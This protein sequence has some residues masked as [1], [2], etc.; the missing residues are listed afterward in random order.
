V[1]LVCAAAIV[2][3]VDSNVLDRGGYHLDKIVRLRQVRELSVT[4][5]PEACA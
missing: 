3:A 5:N 1:C 2:D 4:G